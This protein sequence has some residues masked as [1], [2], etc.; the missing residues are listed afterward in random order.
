LHHYRVTISVD[1]NDDH[2]TPY[3]SEVVRSLPLKI[4]EAVDTV[5]KM[6]RDLLLDEL[7]SHEISWEVLELKE[8]ASGVLKI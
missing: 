4:E 3:C 8:Y 2:S 7:D 6:V 1:E 5:K